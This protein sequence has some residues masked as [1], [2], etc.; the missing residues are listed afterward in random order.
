MARS[1]RISE[2]F[3]LYRLDYII[4]KNQSK[5]AEESNLTCARSLVSYYGDFPIESLDYT[6]IRNWKLF[7]DVDK[8]AATVRNY[9]LSLRVVLRFLKIRGFKVIDSDSIPIPDRVR[10]PP[11]Y[12][13]K[14]EVALLI[15]NCFSIRDKAIISLLFSSGLRLTEMINLNRGMIRDG[16]FTVIG[17]GSKPRLCFTDR[18]TMAFLE[19][20]LTTRNDT[21]PALFISRQG[22]RVAPSTVQF[23][24]RDVLRRSG[25][26][27]PITPHKLRH[28]F[29]TNFL[30]N[31]G[32]MRYLKDMMG[33]ES[34]ETTAMYAQVVDMDLQRIYEK[35][36]SV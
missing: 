7:L 9:I 4:F 26:T 12:A 8:D 27:K 10:K 25:I 19:D 35:H 14:E 22:D 21:H 2:A 23:M 24:F 34:L 3:E 6:T 30:E 31:D 28:G 18:R 11:V 13:T 15:E 1:L 29:A 16:R 33:H 32:N 5:R 20:Y 36:H 17:K